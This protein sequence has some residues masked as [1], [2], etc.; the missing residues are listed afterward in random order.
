MISFSPV[1][2]L[3]FSSVENIFPTVQ[4]ALKVFGFFFSK[5]VFFR[6][7]LL[8]HHNYFLSNKGFTFMF[9]LPSASTFSEDKCLFLSQVLFH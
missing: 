3:S 7:F 9:Y 6:G 4:L 5:V 1:R 2:L 8:P